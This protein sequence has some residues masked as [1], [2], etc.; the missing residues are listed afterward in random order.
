MQ[1]QAQRLASSL[2]SPNKFASDPGPVRRPVQQ[3]QAT[4]TATTP[5]N[6]FQIVRSPSPEQAIVAILELGQFD[7]RYAKQSFHDYYIEVRSAVRAG[8]YAVIGIEYRNDNGIVETL[9]PVAYALW[10]NLTPFT[11]AIYAKKL[12][13]LAPEEYNR[14]QE[15][16][17]FQFCCPFGMQKE[18]WDYAQRSI[19]E[20]A[21]DGKLLTL[22]LFEPIPVDLVDSPSK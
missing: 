1:N 9:T 5:D 15:R 12:R 7:L 20:L 21:K 22:E 16:W 11:A 17:L 3:A 2:S 14:G 4:P 13:S 6:L 8:N 18:V 19:P 10:G